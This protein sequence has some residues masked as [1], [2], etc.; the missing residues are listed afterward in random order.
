[1]S[2]GRENHPSFRGSQRLQY[3]AP[4]SS[5]GDCSGAATSAVAQMVL[6]FPGPLMQTSWHC[7]HRRGKVWQ[8]S[9][10]KM[11]AICPRSQRAGE[12]ESAAFQIPLPTAVTPLLHDH[13][14]APCPVPAASHHRHSPIRKSMY[15]SPPLS[16]RTFFSFCPSVSVAA[17]LGFSEGLSNTLPF[18]VARTLPGGGQG[19]CQCPC[20]A[21]MQL[22]QTHTQLGRPIPSAG[23]IWKSL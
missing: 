16:T 20:S 18:R 12:T 23:E 22:T 14:P 15:P 19:C 6:F 1:M 4:S 17:V 2:S 10:R 9:T 5:I 7:R 3:R 11:L 21:P 13:S 8:P